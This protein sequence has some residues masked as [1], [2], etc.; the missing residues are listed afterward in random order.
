[1]T[2]AR[3]YANAPKGVVAQ[4]AGNA[5]TVIVVVV[6]P[7]LP[8][9]IKQADVAKSVVA[10]I[11]V[12]H[13]PRVSAPLHRSVRTTSNARPV[14]RR[15][16]PMYRP[17]GDATQPMRHRV[18]VKSAGAVMH[19]RHARRVSALICPLNGVNHVHQ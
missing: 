9:L 11:I 1:M 15:T 18:G 3:R 19:S 17:N 4:V 5:P 16:D 8:V 12:H 7:V 14:H 10:V 6:T 13:A 2:W